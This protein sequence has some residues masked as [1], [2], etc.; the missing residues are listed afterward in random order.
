[1]CC[2]PDISYP[3][4]YYEQGH[5]TRNA[6]HQDVSAT[7]SL[8]GAHSPRKFVCRYVLPVIVRWALKIW[9]SSRCGVD[10][11]LHLRLFQVE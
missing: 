7:S 5:E 2:I 11:E 1:M 4:S 6:K 8:N 9:M 10:L 3:H